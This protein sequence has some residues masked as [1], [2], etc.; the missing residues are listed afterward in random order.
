MNRAGHGLPMLA[1]MSRAE[2]E[3]W[4]RE[5]GEPVF[6]GRQLA[7]WMFHRLELNPRQ[8][9][10]LPH[11]LRELAATVLAAPA[12]RVTAVDAAEDGTEKLLVRLADGQSVEMVLIPAEA[13]MTFCLSTQVGCPVRCRFCASGAEGLVRNLQAGEIIE[14]LV[15]GARRIGRLPDNVVFMGIGEGL[16][17]LEELLRAIESMVSP[18]GFGMSPRRLTVSTSG[19]VPGIRR[20]AEFGRE[21]TLA[22]SLHAVNDE[23][24]ARLIPDGFRYPVCEILAAVDEYRERAGRMVT[25]E[26]TLLDGVNDSPADARELA[27]ISREHHAKINL[28]PYNATDTAFRRPPRRVLETFFRTVEQCGGRVTMR[29]ER[30]SSRTAACGQLRRRHAAG[31]EDVLSGGE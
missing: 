29:Q 31:S 15:F 3:Q 16:L 28:I 14:E 19:I 17:N 5:Q 1:G 13:R 6:R 12:G 18:D 20:L 21:L 10:N 4:V 23:L 25:L 24:R 9:T 22:V 7:D 11:S 2:L 30:G 27:R 8:M 26:Y